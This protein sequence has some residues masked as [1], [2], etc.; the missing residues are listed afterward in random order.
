M[1]TD[2][3]HESLAA[4][5]DLMKRPRKLRGTQP[6]TRPVPRADRKTRTNP[7]PDATDTVTPLDTVFLADAR[8][9]EELPDASIDLVVTSPPYFN[10]KDYSLDGFQG[11]QHSERHADQ[12]GDIRAFD[13]FIA[14][15]QMVWRECARVLRPNGKLIINAPLVP[16][17][18]RDLTTHENR[19]IFDLNAE[20][21]SS[22]VRG[23]DGMFLMDT[24]IW[25]RTNPTKK[26]M[27]G[28]YPFP[29]NFYAQNTVEFV[30]V[31]VKEGK[32][33]RRP[34]E[35]REASKLTQD[36]WVE[37]TKQVWD[38]PIPNKSDPAFGK[39][40]ALMPEE[41]AR[42]CVRL[43]SCVGDVVLDPFAGSGTTCRIAQEQGRHFVGYEIVEEY[44]A[45]IEEKLGKPA[46]VQP[47]RSIRGPK[48]R[49]AS[50]AQPVDVAPV[51][52]GLLDE[53]LE[54]D[55]HD[56]LAKLPE[57]S[58]HLACVD[59][60]YNLGKGAWDSW[61]S[62]DS[63][64]EFTRGWLDVLIPTL[65]PGGALFVFNTPRNAAWILGYLEERGMLFENWVTW[66]KRDGFSSTRKR[67][68]PTQESLLFLRKPGG[69]PFFDA[70][71]VREPYQSSERIAAAARTGILKNGKRWFPNPAGRLATD[72]WHFPSERH[73]AKVA[74]RVQAGKHPTQKPSALIERIVL[75]TTRPGEV[76]LDC[77]VGSG[78]T[79]VVAAKNGRHFVASDAD[80]T[81]VELARERVRAATSG[82][83]TTGAA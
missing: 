5:G 51:P 67:F 68:V 28:S 24:Y 36:E 7:G 50:R 48:A 46:C 26:L 20:I 54:C 11:S 13:E 1:D 81:Y 10:I 49:R 43:Y 27:F 57:G 29:P 82:A 71:A 35:Q 47:A 15:L 63:F 4:A 45:L 58:V 40:T 59:P 69:S 3:D 41:I 19:H 16:M 21:Q 64:R 66:D 44:A 37:Y 42:R 6:Y 34:P 22:I 32:G 78:T 75:A 25:N 23:V 53:V 14:Q 17:L 33:K 12:L 62:E 55:A 18:K 52:P 83:R 8:S 31:Y 70:D 79:A 65:I 30:T 77:F 73:T 80:A 74:G 61:P 72:V 60:P 56:L 2:D 38:L 39:H 76:V 9:M